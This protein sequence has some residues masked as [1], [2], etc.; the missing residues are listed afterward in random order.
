MLRDFSPTPLL[1]KRLLERVMEEEEGYELLRF[2]SVSQLILD[3]PRS[4][5]GQYEWSDDMLLALAGIVM[6]LLPRLFARLPRES[7]VTCLNACSQAM[8]PRSLHRGKISAV[9]SA[10][11]VVGLSGFRALQA[12]PSSLVKLLL[13]R[14]EGVTDISYLDRT[15]EVRFAS[16]NESNLEAVALRLDIVRGWSLERAVGQAPYPRGEAKLG[17]FMRYIVDDLTSALFKIHTMLEVGII[18]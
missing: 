6:P 5:A 1:N 7:F 13:T 12:K 2:D 16:P 17:R 15:L 18:R 10:G 3:N 11:K 4:L 14:P 8:N 9:V